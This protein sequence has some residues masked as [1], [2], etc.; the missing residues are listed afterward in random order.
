MSINVFESP[1]T[2]KVKID[3]TGVIHTR[4]DAVRTFKYG[5]LDKP[6]MAVTVSV[7]VQYGEVHTTEIVDVVCFNPVEFDAIVKLK[8]KAG[9]KVKFFANK[10]ENG[11]SIGGASDISI[12]GKI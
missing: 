3:F 2:G 1:L 11:L 5:A 8:L 6:A 7:P 9:V 4:K 12:V 10:T